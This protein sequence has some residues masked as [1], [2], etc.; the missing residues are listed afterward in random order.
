S[1]FVSA[2]L[3]VAPRFEKG[4]VLRHTGERLPSM[5]HIEMTVECLRA[6]GVTVETPGPGVWKIGHQPT[7]ARDLTIEPDLSNAAPFLAAA[8]VAGGTVTIEDWPARTTQV[9][10]HLEHLLPQFGAKVTRTG[11]ALTVDGGAGVRGGEQLPG[12]ELDL[13]EGGELAPAL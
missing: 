12:V 4:L 13:S 7:A 8:L 3:M 10:A 2:L 11:D 1:Q 6:R 5:P 9:G